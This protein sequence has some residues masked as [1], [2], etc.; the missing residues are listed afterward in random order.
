M[1]TTLD[2]GPLADAAA[3]YRAA[4]ARLDDA[5]GDAEAAWQLLPAALDSPG[6]Q[7]AVGRYVGPA[8]RLSTGLLAAADELH[9]A[10]ASET[11][12][13]RLLQWEAEA[14][15][16]DPSWGTR[17]DATIASI[18][19]GIAAIRGGEAGSVGL[20]C[21]TPQAVKHGGGLAVRPATLVAP[22]P[23]SAGIPDFADFVNGARAVGSAIASG[24]EAAGAAAATGVW[25]AG[26]AT[27]AGLLGVAG[28]VL[29]MGGSTASPA[30]PGPEKGRKTG[31]HG[32]PDRITDY[33][34]C[35]P[36]VH[37]EGCQHVLRA[38]G[39]KP[40]DRPFIGDRVWGDEPPGEMPGTGKD[41]TVEPTRNG[42]G[43][44]YRAPDGRS[45]RVMRPAWN[46]R[47]PNGDVVFENPGGQPLDLSMKTHT[48]PDMTHIVRNTD[49]SFPI[50]KGWGN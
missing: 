47:Y 38:L 40:G 48:G 20:P 49:G 6:T 35:S 34:P 41:W 27:T 43:L 5:A 11:A 7:L 19:A 23:V 21:P 4:V 16:D 29:S 18:A 32:D 1:T 44:I 28:L 37:G 50:P 36:E 10:L 45:L 3:D 33:Q 9:A 42:K 12:H 25:V 15:P 24:L 26:A 13:L 14:H 2:L 30:G 8:H 17:A 46:N 39:E 31:K 22:G